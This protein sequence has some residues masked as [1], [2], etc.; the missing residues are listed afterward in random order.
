MAKIPKD[1]VIRTAFDYLD[2]KK[3]HTFRKGETGTWKEK[4]TEIHKT[5]M[6]NIAGDLLIELNY[7]KN[8]N[9]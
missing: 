8:K 1:E 4:F 5:Q 7:E 6:K 9:W 2:P 3:S